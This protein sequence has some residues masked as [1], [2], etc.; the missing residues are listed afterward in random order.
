MPNQ[1]E[2]QAGLPTFQISPISAFSDNYIWC[3]HNGN[4]AYVVDP[5]DAKPVSA[6]LSE[7]RLELKGILITHHHWDHTNGID[8]L[9]A[10][11]RDIPVFGPS[12]GTVKQVTQPLAAGDE[13]TLPEFDVR[14]SVLDV[15]GHTLDHIAYVGEIALFCGD[16]L[17]SG[18]CGRLFEGTPAQMHSSL[19]LLKQL[20]ESLPVYCTHEYTTANLAFA[21]TVDPGNSDLQAYDS[22]VK[23][24]RENQLPT[25]PSSIG[26]E[27][28]INPFLRTEN[29]DIKSSVER[30]AAK[31]LHS[32]VEVFAGL[33]SWKD[34][35]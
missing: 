14:F 19:T 9:L 3:L 18:G 15:P 22:W 34:N 28:A 23:T 33:R 4:D 6:F 11:F 2:S 1:I 8:D 20:P 21:L 12:A 31:V 32:E 30:Y 27:L 7:K 25:L 29:H 26:R 16:T 35:F 17:F 24:Q 10:Q 5:G 13:I